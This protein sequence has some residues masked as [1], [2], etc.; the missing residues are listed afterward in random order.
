MDALGNFLNSYSEPLAWIL[1]SVI[2]LGMIIAI[3]V[4]IKA[5]WKYFK[6]GVYDI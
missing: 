6:K 1:A 2:F 3:S 5:L 4:I